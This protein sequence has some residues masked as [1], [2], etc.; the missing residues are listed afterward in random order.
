MLSETSLM[1]RDATERH[2]VRGGR[3][4]ART[5]IREGH[6]HTLPDCTDREYLPVDAV[7]GV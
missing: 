2:W 6:M 3:G 5:G 1:Q 4:A 7:C